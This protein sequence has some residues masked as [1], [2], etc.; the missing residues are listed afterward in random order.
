MFL[1]ELSPAE[2]NRIGI[3]S[4]WSHELSG[5]TSQLMRNYVH[6]KVGIADD[7]W[8]TVGSANLDGVSL[9]K[10]QY[11]PL[12]GSPFIDLAGS[13]N[14]KRAIE[15]NALLFNNVEGLPA[16]HAPD[17]LRRSLWSEHLGYNNPNHPD[18]LKVNQPAGGWLDL[19]NRIARRKVSSLNATPPTVDSGR[20][21]P[22]PNTGGLSSYSDTE[23]LKL[24]GINVS[25]HKIV[26]EVRSFDFDTGK[27][28]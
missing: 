8:A 7:S 11:I 26:E 17:E 28:V 3:F 24:S 4:L 16:S 6:S 27:W 21:L 22:W 5:T 12:M 10:S 9:R 14:L 2:K 23:F 25:G 19:W 18:L 20:I 1:D 13:A 15:V